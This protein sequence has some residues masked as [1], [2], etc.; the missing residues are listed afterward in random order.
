MPIEFR[1][2]RCG[3]LL[4]T[5]DGTAGRQAQCPECGTI[6]TVPGAAETGQPEAPPWDGETC[7]TAVHRPASEDRSRGPGRAIGVRR[8][9]GSRDRRL[10]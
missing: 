6:G 1:C 9:T 8:P 5:G 2:S 4:R 10:A 3:K 7:G